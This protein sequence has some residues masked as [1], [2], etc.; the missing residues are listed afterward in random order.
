MIDNQYNI[1]QPYTS[2]N[3]WKATGKLENNS[4]PYKRSEI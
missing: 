1:E 4:K 3:N 2:K